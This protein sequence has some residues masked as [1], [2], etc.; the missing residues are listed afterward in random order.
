MARASSSGDGVRVRMGGVQCDWVL[1]AA[2][3][4]AD[5]LWAPVPLST[6]PWGAL[7]L[8]ASQLTKYSISLIL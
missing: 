1:P 4:L 5:H 8:C 2:G 3:S 7:L 6:T